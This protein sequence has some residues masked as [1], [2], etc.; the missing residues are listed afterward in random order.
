MDNSAINEGDWNKEGELNGVQQNKT[1]S[2]FAKFSTRKTLFGAVDNR[3]ISQSL[4]SN[5]LPNPLPVHTSKKQT[6]NKKR[7]K[8]SKQKKTK[9]TKKR[10][11]TFFRY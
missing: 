4:D 8:N 11:L 1:N 9:K 2:S 10:I 7:K 6:N 5:R 3:E